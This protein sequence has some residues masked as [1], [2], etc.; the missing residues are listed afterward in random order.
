MPRLYFGPMADKFK[1]EYQPFGIGMDELDHVVLGDWLAEQGASETGRSYCGGSR[2]SSKEKP[3]TASDVSAL[4][5][6]WQES[7]VKMRGL[8]VFKREVFRLKGGNQLLPDTFAKHLGDRVRKNC[9][10]TVLEH[11]AN[12]VT[13]TFAE[14]PDKREQMH[15]ADYAVMCV[16]PMVIAGIKV[17]PGWPETK[18][19]ALEHTP[20]LLYTSRCV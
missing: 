16:S 11:D 4:Y 9:L 5:R 2:L 8:P 14:G 1:D 3:A 19:F 7:I 18:K 6:I 10:V 13:V 17:S 15:K 12:G 20:C